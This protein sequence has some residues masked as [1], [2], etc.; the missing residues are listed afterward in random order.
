[1]LHFPYTD[2]LGFQRNIRC[3]VSHPKGLLLLVCFL[4][5]LLSKLMLISS[6]K[7]RVRVNTFALYNS[8]GLS[9]ILGTHSLDRETLLPK[10]VL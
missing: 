8:D 2:A 5:T 3:C 7:Y 9:P 4:A 6:E 1:M 10:V